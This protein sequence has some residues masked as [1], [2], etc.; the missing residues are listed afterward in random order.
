MKCRRK[1]E[2]GRFI[3]LRVPRSRDTRS[4]I[5]QAVGESPLSV[6]LDRLQQGGQPH[7]A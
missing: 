6:L 7:S 5:L 1:Q 3:A 2:Q 4:E